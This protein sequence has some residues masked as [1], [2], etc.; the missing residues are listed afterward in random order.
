[1]LMLIS[2][3]FFFIFLINV[4]VR[5]SLRVPQLIPQA[6]KLMTM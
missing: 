3:Q 4:G 6:L 5:A 2:M 1:M